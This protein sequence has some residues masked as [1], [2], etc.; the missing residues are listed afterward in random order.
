MFNFSLKAHPA[1]IHKD[2]YLYLKSDLIEDFIRKNLPSSRLLV[3]PKIK[4]SESEILFH[5]SEFV[6]FKSLE[7]FSISEKRNILETYNKILYEVEDLCQH[8]FEADAS[9]SREWADILKLVFNRNNNYIFYN[10]GLILLCWGF[11]F[12]SYDE[13]YIPRSEIFLENEDHILTP[14]LSESGSDYVPEHLEPEIQNEPRITDESRNNPNI[15]VRSNKRNRP[16]F[17]KT[18]FLGLSRFFL[19]TWPLLLL[20]LL[21]YFLGY[22]SFCSNCD[23]GNLSGGSGT[24]NLEDPSAYLP[25]PGYRRPPVDRR[26]LVPDDDSV[27]QIVSNRVNVAIKGRNKYFR[28]FVTDLGRNFLNSE[29]KII[30]YDSNSTRVQ[31][32]FDAAKESDIKSVIRTSMSGYDLLIWDEAV[33]NPARSFSDPAYSERDKNWYFNFIGM[34][35]A[36]DI[37]VGDTGTL[38]AVIDNAFDL[39]HPELSS[40]NIVSPYNVV[41]QNSAVSAGIGE[42]HGTHV[43]GTACGSGNNRSG[44]VGIAPNCSF[45]PVQISAGNEILTSTDIIDGILYAVKHGADVIN[46]SLGKQIMPGIPLEVQQRIIDQEGK[47]EEEFWNEML[48]NIDSLG[49]C[50]V[51]AAG[52]DGVLAGIDPMHRT[53][54]GIVVGAI[55]SAKTQR[56]AFSNFGSAVDID[57]PGVG[58]YSSIPGRSYDF[59]MGTS[60]ACPIVTGAVALYKSIKPNAKL[61]EVKGALVA[62]SRMGSGPNS[63]KIIQVNQFLQRARSAS[64]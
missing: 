10:E 54:F 33:F 37:T 32:L 58:I 7:S 38:I 31:I 24:G 30:D 16:G 53:R 19:M 21:L 48:S 25:G 50:V 18:I 51:M 8:L 57:A 2:A 22:L 52:N 28:S 49:I 12:G 17:W 63:P 23:K 20:L 40:K 35:R 11:K 1:L 15:R 6:N 61:A 43:A 60:M 9:A 41:T 44:M 26:D 64:R 39:T 62:T 13:Y 56:A 34:E 3:F 42:S 47:D 29:R 4:I 5:G 45:M 59:M 14:Q 46:L 55:D 27:F 36:W